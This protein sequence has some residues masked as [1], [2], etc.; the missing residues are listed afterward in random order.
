VLL[1]LP[2]TMALGAA[3]PPVVP[4][5]SASPSTAAP[6]SARWCV[7]DALFLPAVDLGF[8]LFSVLSSKKSPSAMDER[9]LDD[10]DCRLAGFRSS[11]GAAG[12]SLSGDEAVKS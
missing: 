2:V 6:R 10:L 9:R 7:M 4:I 11:I 3:S 5:V 1:L 8:C 12:P